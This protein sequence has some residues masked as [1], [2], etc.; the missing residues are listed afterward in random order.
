MTKA[1]DNPFPSILLEDH[2]DPAAPTNGFHRLFIDTDEK[3]KMIDHASLVTDFTPGAGGS[4]AADPIWD[5]AG[6]LAVGT[7]AD[8][9]GRLAAGAA[10]GVLA[11]GNSA[12]IWNAGT[13]F[14]ASKATG[15]RYWRTDLGLEFYWDGTRWVSTTEYLLPLTNI[16]AAMPFSSSTDALY[17]PVPT[18]GNTRDIWMVSFEWAAQQAPT[19]DGSNYWTITLRKT[20]SWTTIVAPTTAGLT[21]SVWGHVST[22]IGAALGTATAGLSVYAVKTNSAGNLYIVG[23][24]RYRVIGT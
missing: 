16:A 8:T 17:S 5:A 3:L 14:P 11:M 19:L 1:S 2:V 4:V 7:G 13:S 21:Q 18:I 6:D 23:A 22:S 24:L 15:D 10:G 20:E 12:V 9:A